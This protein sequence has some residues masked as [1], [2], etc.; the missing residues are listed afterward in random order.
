[1]LIM[2]VLCLS[3]NATVVEL[4][5]TDAHDAGLVVVS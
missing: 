5:P 2:L 1:M 4:G 3:L